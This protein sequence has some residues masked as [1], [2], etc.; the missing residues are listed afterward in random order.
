ME[1]SAL[2]VVGPLIHSERI[3]V[4]IGDIPVPPFV[5]DTVEV[6]HSLLQ[7]RHQQRTV[8]PAQIIAEETTLNIANN[9]I[10]QE[11]LPERIEEQIA[12]IPF[13]PTVEEIE[14]SVRIV[15]ERVQLS[16]DEQVV[17]ALVLQIVDEQLVVVGNVAK[18]EFLQI[19][20]KTFFLSV[21]VDE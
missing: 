21:Y 9:E 15:Q 6:V 20:R 4:Q 11:R 1:T 3:E 12:G 10:P 5:D 14:E 16:I 19:P 17:D 7:E 8:D 18:W 2:Q 13:P